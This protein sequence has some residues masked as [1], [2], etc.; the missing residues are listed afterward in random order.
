MRKSEYS[1][2]RI[3]HIISSI[4]LTYINFKIALPDRQFPSSTFDERPV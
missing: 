1:D 3:P 4:Q 2:L